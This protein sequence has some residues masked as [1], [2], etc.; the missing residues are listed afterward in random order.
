MSEAKQAPKGQ[1]ST[2]ARV[3]VA[4]TVRGHKYQPNDLIAGESADQAVA[5]GQADASASAVAKARKEG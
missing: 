3:L 2:E 5:N 1:K 4:C